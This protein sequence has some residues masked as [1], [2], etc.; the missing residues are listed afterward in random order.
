[1]NV[2]ICINSFAIGNGRINKNSQK[3][4]CLAYVYADLYTAMF[5]DENIEG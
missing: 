4:C 5:E 2:K 1:M 3:M